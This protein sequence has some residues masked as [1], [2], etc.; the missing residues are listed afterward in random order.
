MSTLL[1]NKSLL[2][3]GLPCYQN[4]SVY[5]RIIRHY[6]LSYIYIYIYR[7]LCPFPTTIIIKSQTPLNTYTHTY[8]HIYIYMCI[9]I[10]TQWTGFK[11]LTNIFTFQHSAISL[12]KATIPL[13][14]DKCKSRLGSSTL[15]YIYIYIYI[16]LICDE[17]GGCCWQIHSA[18][19]KIKK[20]I[21]G[22]KECAEVSCDQEKTSIAW[23][24]CV[25][26]RSRILTEVSCR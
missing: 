17:P 5:C 3:F 18:V 9:Y 15:V 25:Y 11:S 14:I 8:K 19:D 2:L 7:E 1:L 13:V 24:L 12:W 21:T 6:L 4:F 26:I 10:W 22:N 23:V 16:T 20:M